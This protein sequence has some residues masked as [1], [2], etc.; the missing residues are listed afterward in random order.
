[1]NDGTRQQRFNRH[2]PRE[3]G[4]TSPLFLFLFCVCGVLYFVAFR[5]QFLNFMQLG[6]FPAHFWFNLQFELGNKRQHYID[7]DAEHF[8]AR[9]PIV[10]C[11]HVCCLPLHTACEYHSVMRKKT[12]R[13]QRWQTNVAQMS[14]KTKQNKTN[15][16]MRV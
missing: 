4:E 6:F 7:L 2:D 12:R 3:A 10:C 8:S 14:L 11:L 16:A 1:V 13:T 9:I 5:D 15:K